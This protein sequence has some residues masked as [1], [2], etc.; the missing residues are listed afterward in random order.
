MLKAHED[1]VKER[2]EAAE[3][4]RTVYGGPI[5]SVS[6]V[7]DVKEDD[8]EIK[9]GSDDKELF[10]NSNGEVVAYYSNNL[11]KKFSNKPRSWNFKSKSF[12]GI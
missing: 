2:N 1:D 10:T 12:S 4:E 3:K 6:K 8:S 5:S 7:K 11:A 9:D